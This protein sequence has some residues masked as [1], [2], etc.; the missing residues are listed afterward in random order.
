[1]RDSGRMHSKKMEGINM[2]CPDKHKYHRDWE[3]IGYDTLLTL[4]IV[5][6]IAILVFLILRI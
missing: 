2:T 1:M 4:S 6:P 5:T 3:D